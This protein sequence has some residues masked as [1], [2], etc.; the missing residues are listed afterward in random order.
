MRIIYILLLSVISLFALSPEQLKTLQDVRDIA[1]TI[2]D[3]YGETYENTISAICLTESSAGR[4]II[5]DFHKGTDITKASLGVMQV[6][7]ATAK[8]VAKYR[9]DFAFLILKTDA[10]IANLLLTDVKLSAKVAATYLVMLVNARPTYYNAVSG[11]NGGMNNWKYYKRV[12][13]HM[14]LVKK[15]VKSGRLS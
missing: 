12:S 10:E 6:Q 11:Y 9:R 2:P 8:H 7:V 3:K 5:G 4:N 14:D 13:R 15:L 1:K